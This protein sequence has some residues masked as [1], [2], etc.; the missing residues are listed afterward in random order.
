MTRTDCPPSLDP[1]DPDASGPK[2]FRKI[3]DMLANGETVKSDDF[4]AY[5]S[6]AV[7]EALREMFHGKCA[8][9]ESKIAGSQD[10]DVEHYRPRRA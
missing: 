2:E 1:N 10:T 7:R 4:S 8:Y 5:G 9:C 3:R 6:R